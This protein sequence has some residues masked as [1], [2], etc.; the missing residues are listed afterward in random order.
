MTPQ[1]KKTLDWWAD[2]FF[3]ICGII[4]FLV[5]ANICWLAYWLFTNPFNYPVIVIP[6][7]IEAIILL[8]CAFYIIVRQSLRVFTIV[9][10]AVNP[11]LYRSKNNDEG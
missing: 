8:L 6:I 7:I 11:E 5:M 4:F 1:Q 10:K 3:I 2:R 9:N